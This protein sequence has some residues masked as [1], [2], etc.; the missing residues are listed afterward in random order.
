MHRIL[1][2]RALTVAALLT[3]MALKSY[4]KPSDSIKRCSRY[5]LSI[6]QGNTD[7]EI[8]KDTIFDCIE[9]LFSSVSKDEMSVQKLLF[10]KNEE[11]ITFKK[12]SVIT[13]SGQ[14][15][16]PRNKEVVA[17]QSNNKEGENLQ[18]LTE[19]VWFCR[20]HYK[21]ASTVS[22]LKVS[23]SCSHHPKPSQ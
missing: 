21:D 10:E 14:K 23:F 6:E 20:I 8:E 7:K 11:S 19:G 3:M 2:G 12:L 17:L 1:T 16:L 4:P 9:E 5:K 13:E 15:F 22:T 18:R